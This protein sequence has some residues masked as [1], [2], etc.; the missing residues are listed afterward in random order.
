TMNRDSM[1]VPRRT[2]GV[3]AFFVGEGAAPLEST[4]TWDEVKL[5]A[6]K[7]A[8]L[9]RMS[10]ELSEDSLINVA[11]WI[12]TEIAYAFASKEDD[13]LFSGDGTQTYGGINGLKNTIG[14]AGVYTATGHATF[15]VL[16]TA[17][18]SML[19]GLLPQYALPG[20]KFFCS[21][22][23]YAAVFCRLGVAASGNTI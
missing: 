21:Q 16:T 17:D 15:D 20:A 13:C 5:V 3:S 7:C 23:F 2:G 6:K 12:V 9:V 11:D 14:S 4:A 10:T 18:I 1:S 22:S 19:M 8:A